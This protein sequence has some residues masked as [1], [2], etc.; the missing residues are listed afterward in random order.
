MRR[1]A[2]LQPR[3]FEGQF[4]LTQAV[5]SGEISLAVTSYDSAV[6][7]VEKGA[8]VKLAG[9]DPTPLSLI[10]GG[11]LKYGKNPNT[12]RLFLSWLATT[13]GAITFEKMTKRGNFFVAGTETAKLLKDRKLSF[14]TAE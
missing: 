13:E 8:P 12:A 4:P 11:V 6:L 7:V 3:L 9:L 2:A 5:G 14:F 1:L 10:C